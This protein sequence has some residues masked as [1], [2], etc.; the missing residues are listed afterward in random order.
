MLCTT[1][2]LHITIDTMLQCINRHRH[3]MVSHH[4][5][6][7]IYT[8]DTAKMEA[9]DGVPLGLQNHGPV[10]TGRTEEALAYAHR[11]WHRHQSIS[12]K[13][14]CPNTRISLAITNSTNN[15]CWWTTNI[16]NNRSN[17]LP[18]DHITLS[19]STICP[20]VQCRTRSASPT[21]FPNR[22]CLHN[23]WLPSQSWHAIT[24]LLFLTSP[25]F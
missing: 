20:C 11:H 10:V 25:L 14:I 16:T 5:L 22:I 6:L 24:L 2:Y 4:D 23:T 13:Q 1:W 7:N 15:R 19:E 9:K 21:C 3:N 8:T 17:N 12:R 18:L